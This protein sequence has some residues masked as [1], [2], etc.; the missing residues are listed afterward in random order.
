MSSNIILKLQRGKDLTYEETK[1]IMS[2]IMSGDASEDQTLS[3]LSGLTDKGETDA[4]LLGMLDLMRE[5]AVDMMPKDDRRIIDVCGTG[6]DAMHT[7]NIS[8]ASAFVIA[9]SGSAVAK[10]GNRSVSSISGSADVFEY[11]GY[12]LGLSPD[13]TSD[14]LYRFNICFMFAPTFHPAM[15]HVASARKQMGKKTAFNLLGPL[16][17]PAG[18]TGQ[19][20]G[21]HSEYLLDRIPLLLKSRASKETIIMTVRSANG[22]DE[23]TSCAKNS[24]RILRDKDM[25]SDVID[26]ERFGMNTSSESDLQVHTPKEAIKSF[27]SVLDNC[28]N[29]AMTDTVILNSAAGLVV[30]DMADDIS[31]GI[32]I[33]RDTLESGRAATLL[34]H[35]VSSTGDISKLD[36][37]RRP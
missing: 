36:E 24:I 23:L 19:L 25:T 4:E 11:F 5:H 31:S 8:T 12:D 32:E 6:G 10:H 18:V 3:F 35:F 16:C 30:A 34:E 29:E 28:A 15:R 7:F 27:V 17:N 21:V 1:H 22:M 13:S 33:A 9:A 2:D 20:I 14:I 37:V 26:P